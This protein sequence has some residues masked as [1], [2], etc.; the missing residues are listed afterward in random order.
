M[1]NIYTLLKQQYQIE[2]KNPFKLEK[3]PYSYLTKNSK[4][5]IEYNID[6]NLYYIDNNNKVYQLIK[7]SFCPKLARLVG[8]IEKKTIFIY[9]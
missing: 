1:N 5:V 9:K 8:H 7:N 4:D 2:D 3:N 6:N